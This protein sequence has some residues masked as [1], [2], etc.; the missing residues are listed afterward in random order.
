AVVIARLSTG[1]IVR[2]NRAAEKMFG[3]TAAEAIG[4]SIE[5]LMPEPIAQLHRNGLE[6]YVRSGHGLLM[7]ADAPVEMPAR[8]RSGDEVRV[9]LSL[10]EIRNDEGER[11]AVAILRDGAH[12]RQHEL[13]N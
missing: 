6:R 2:W 1:H 5:I 13:T 12:R 10:S 8:T 7:D 11:F 9:E 4:Q 3:Y